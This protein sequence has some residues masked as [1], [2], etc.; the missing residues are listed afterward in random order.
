[1]F[2]L[3]C[4]GR[5]LQAEQPLVM[6]I[7]N[8]TPDS[9]FEASRS[10]ST[11]KLLRLADKMIGHGAAMIDIGGQSTRPG[12]QPVSADDELRRVIDPLR[13]L[14]E[15]FPELVI[16]IDTWYSKVATE[17]VSAGA[18][19]IND[20]SGGSLDPDMIATAGRLQVPYILTHT[21]GTPEN[22]QQ[23][24]RYKAMVPEMLG[25]FT[26]KISLLRMAGVHDIIIDPG[27]GFAKTIP[28]NFSLLRQLPQFGILGLPVLAG[29]S[30]K[31]TV[32][33]TLHIDVSEALNGSTVLH[34]MALMNGANLLRVH[35][36]KEAV[37]AVRLFTA[38]QAAG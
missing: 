23:L 27:F 37:E 17:A 38:Y 4:K 25:Y 24:T 18:A 31:G 6:G 30:R 2:T 1:M 10:Q 22:M 5:L 7:I 16:S 11:D 34:T 8:I 28:Q 33:K 36:V 29:L 20:I 19:I 14:A 3:N 32:Y 9:F 12:S 35:D 21:R 26:E 13:K 15:H